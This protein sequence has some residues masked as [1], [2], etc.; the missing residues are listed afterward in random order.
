MQNISFLTQIFLSIL[1]G[2]G[3]LSHIVKP[4][5][6]QSA[7][8]TITPPVTEILLSPNKK[9]VHSFTVHNQGETLKLSAN[10]HKIMPTDS[11]G[12]TMVDPTP[13]DESS[14]PLIIGI[15][16]ADIKLGEPFTINSGQ[17]QQ[18][19]LSITAANVDLPVDTY[20]GLVFQQFVDNPPDSPQIPGITALILVTLTPD[21]ALPLSLE[22]ADFDL[23]AVHDSAQILTFTP[24][25]KNASS[26]MVRPAGVLEVVS[27]K[28]KLVHSQE[29]FPHLVLGNSERTLTARAKDSSIPLSWQ[30]SK[31]ALGPYKIRLKVMSP[32]GTKLEEVERVVW[33]LPIRAIIITALLSITILIALI[34]FRSH[35]LYY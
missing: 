3:A 15:E 30:A 20:L 16:N 10:L 31:L 18:I 28:G 21:G 27:P 8:L 35:K 14:I 17:A 6:A 1:I 24:K 26:I 7:S 5:F 22:I 9:L 11:W 34:R 23:P 4:T 2:I 12:H 13:L 25:I 29:L 33:I 32:G 19:V